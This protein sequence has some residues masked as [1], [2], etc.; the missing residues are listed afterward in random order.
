ME[1]IEHIVGQGF[2]EFSR[3]FELSFGEAYRALIF[4][5]RG[6]RTYFGNRYV[7]LA[8]K[9]RLSAGEPCEIARQ[10]GFCFVNVELDHDFLL[11]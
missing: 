3:N 5:M 10:M 2:K 11:A 4:S 7:P 9:D 1:R 8:Q 6:N